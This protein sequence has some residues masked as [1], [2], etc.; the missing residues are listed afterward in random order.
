MSASLFAIA[1]L[2]LADVAPATAPQ[3]SGAL[4]TVEQAIGRAVANAMPDVAND[5]FLNWSAFGTRVGRGVSWHLNPPRPYRRRPLPE[6][7]HQRT[8]W[9]SVNGRTGDV[10]VCGDADQVGLMTLT[11]SDIWLG[12]SDVIVALAER[13]VRATLT[14]N[15]PTPAYSPPESER[16][17]QELISRNPARRTWRLEQAG[18]EPVDLRAE[19]SCTPPGTR[20]A[21]RC[22][23]TWSVLFRPDERSAGAE[24]CLPPTRQAAAVRLD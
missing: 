21:T 15:V 20:S 4:E 14:E 17:Y 24:P 8:G 23:M 5:W 3:V 12:D 19:W 10:A 7:V 18:R 9:L 2:T 6:G 22:Q 13:G 1:L 16:Y 11:V